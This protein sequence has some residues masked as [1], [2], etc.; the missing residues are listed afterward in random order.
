MQEKHPSRHDS[1][2]LMACLVS[3]SVPTIISRPDLKIPL[4]HLYGLLVLVAGKS[5]LLSEIT[6]L[7][8][9]LPVYCAFFASRRLPST[10]KKTAA[11]ETREK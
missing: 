4:K 6:G 7:V 2:H 9:R 10:Q 5:Q 3:R 11:I 1:P 8:V